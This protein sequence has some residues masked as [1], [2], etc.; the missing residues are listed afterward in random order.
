[1]KKRVF[2]EKYA[3]PKQDE[4]FSKEELVKEVVKEVKQKT[5][6]KKTTKKKSDK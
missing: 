4:I 6:T 2:R 1:M 5:F 3:I